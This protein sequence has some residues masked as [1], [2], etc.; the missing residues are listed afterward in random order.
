LNK[1]EFVE[2]LYSRTTNLTKAQAANVTDIAIA[3]LTEQ[4]AAKEK[5]QFVGFGTFEARFTPKRKARNPRTGEETTIPE[6]Y[7][8]AFKAG[9]LLRDKVNGERK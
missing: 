2:E 4:M 8:P 1:K 9:K 7:R 3:I 6:G 5:V